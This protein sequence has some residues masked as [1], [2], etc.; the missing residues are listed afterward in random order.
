MNFMAKETKRYWLT[1]STTWGGQ[2]AMEPIGKENVK[3]FKMV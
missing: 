2:V 1:F 3:P